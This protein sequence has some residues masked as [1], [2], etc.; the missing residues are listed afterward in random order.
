MMRKLLIL[1]APAILLA[2]SSTS[3]YQTDVNGRRQE[4]AEHDSD[5]K[6]DTA[7]R[8]KSIN[9]RRVPLDQTIEKVLRNDASGRVVEKTI[10]RY[11]GT[12]HVTQTIKV[13]VEETRLSGGNS[14][15]RETTSE[16]DMN[17][18][19]AQTQRRTTETQVTGQTKTSNVTIDQPSINGSFST[20][21][22]RNT[23]ATGAQ[24][25]QQ[26][27]ETVQRPDSSGRF[28]PVIRNETVLKSTPAGSNENSANYQ[29]DATGRMVL[30]EQKVTTTTKRPGGGEVVESSIYAP[31]TVGQ[32]SPTGALRIKEQQVVDKRVNPD[33]SVVETLVV[34]HASISDP[35]VLGDPHKVSETVCTGKCLPEPAKP[36][37]APAPATTAAAKK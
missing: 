21:E 5:G 17:G 15:V 22:R 9:G 3:T 8:Y 37:A 28:R 34:R 20:V 12:G 6:G 27:T 18:R 33:G 14:V 1:W 32:V 4:V 26:L 23:V 31:N 2:Q 10:Q 36:A 16:A 35:R 25:N 30:A 7:E 19:Y 13:L 29:L 11:D 24:D